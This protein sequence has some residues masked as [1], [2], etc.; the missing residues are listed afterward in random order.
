MRWY[1]SQ[2][3]HMFYFEKRIY[4]FKHSGLI[5]KFQGQGREGVCEKNIFFAWYDR[6]NI[7]LGLNNPARVYFFRDNIR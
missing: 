1:K 4:F 2:H 5:F 3:D 6:R 7:P